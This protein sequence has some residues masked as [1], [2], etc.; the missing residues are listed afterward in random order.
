MRITYIAAAAFG[1]ALT[2]GSSAAPPAHAATPAATQAA[3][4][5]GCASPVGRG[6]SAAALLRRFGRNARKETVP[7]AEGETSEAIVLYPRDAMRR[8]EVIYADA[9]MLRPSSVTLRTGRSAWSVAGMRL[10]DSLDQVAQR[11]GRDFA[12]SG[13]EWDYGGYVTD[14]KGG[15]LARLP[16]G[17]TISIRFSLP[18]NLASTPETLMGDVQLQSNNPALRRVRPVVSALALSWR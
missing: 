4:P 7:G 10:G 15:A 17:C 1:L 2:A 3:N 11:N 9:R 13:F 14:L 5:V 18:A 16:G 12:M 6:D 8:I